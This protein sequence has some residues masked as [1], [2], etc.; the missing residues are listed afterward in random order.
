MKKMEIIHTKSNGSNVSAIR[1]LCGFV[2]LKFSKGGADFP[3]GNEQ[4]VT[5]FIKLSPQ[6]LFHRRGKMNRVQID[7]TQNLCKN[8]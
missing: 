5:N 6:L 2:N 1:H 7:E 8:T 3:R 4:N